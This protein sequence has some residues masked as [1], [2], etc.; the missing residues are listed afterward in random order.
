MTGDARRRHWGVVPTY[1]PTMTHAATQQAT[2]HP[3]TNSGVPVA[4]NITLGI[5]FLG[6]AAALC[7][8]IALG[9]TEGDSSQSLMLAAL[10]VA[11]LAGFWARSYGAWRPWPLSIDGVLAALTFAG[12]PG[13]LIHQGDS[14]ANAL[15]FAA[16]LA[17]RNYMLFIGLPR[18]YLSLRC[19][20]EDV[21]TRWLLVATSAVLL[22]SVFVAYTHG[23]SFQTKVR[24]TGED[25]NW[26]NAN[27][28]GAYAAA[29][30]LV[31]C[32]APSLSWR[33]RFAVGTLAAY[34]LLLA[35]ARTAIGGLVVALGLFAYLRSSGRRLQ[36]LAGAGVAAAL[37]FVLA[38]S[39]VGEVTLPGP[40]QNMLD[41]TFDPHGG[42]GEATA[43]RVAITLAALDHLRESPIIG[44]GYLAPGSRIDVAYVSL[45]VE[46]GVIGLSLYMLFMGFVLWRARRGAKDSQDPRGQ[47]L[48]RYVLCFTVFLLT[49]AVAERGHGFQVGSVVAN[50]W[51]LLCGVMFAYQA[52]KHRSL[53]QGAPGK[54][55]RRLRWGQ[56]GRLQVMRGSTPN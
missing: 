33:T 9:A 37:L 4:L 54:R 42:A 14:T 51:L 55:R 23:V 15:A 50:A 36:F 45:A 41:R 43:G 12:V 52:R 13:I 1:G 34:V 39:F 11:C 46:S 25:M 2:H 44:F 10:A 22:V 18:A 21:V 30:F 31:C 29:A 7:V 28:T 27:T 40:V 16:S 35:Q 5:L 19:R 56:P 26:L 8:P 49:H 47:A 17:L 32:I 3:R 53:R 6:M 48:A 38:I 24:L 20:A